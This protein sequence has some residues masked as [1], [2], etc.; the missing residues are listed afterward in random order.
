MQAMHAISFASFA[1]DLQENGL[2]SMQISLW[3]LY[4][5]RPTPRREMVSDQEGTQQ[6]TQTLRTAHE[7]A[8]D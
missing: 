8:R 3:R 1:G 2:V 5:G 6:R 4:A 7:A